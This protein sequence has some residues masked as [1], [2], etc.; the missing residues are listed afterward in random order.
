MPPTTPPPGAVF[1]MILIVLVALGTVMML[2]LRAAAWWAARRSYVVWEGGSD[3]SEGGS[4]TSSAEP[5][6]PQQNQLEPELV[7]DFEAV[8]TFLSSHNL[9]D[10]EAVIL[11]AV[12]RR[13]GD[14]LISANKIRDVVGGSDAQIKA[15]V[16]AIRPRPRTPPVQRLERPAGGW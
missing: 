14:Y 15:Q 8:K 12:L 5:V 4:G 10:D 7:R 11:L 16:A 1:V 9:S 2:A 6:L 13:N 3:E